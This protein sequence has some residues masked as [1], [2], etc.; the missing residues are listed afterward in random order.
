MKKKII[1][2]ITTL[3][4]CCALVL[5]INKVKADSGWDSDY[6]S[7]WDSSS[8]WDS[9]SSSSWDS[10]SRSSW[11]PNSGSGVTTYSDG[12]GS[13][14]ILVVFLIIIIA[15]L[16]M[17]KYNLNENITKRD[18]MK[19]VD[20]ELL[21]KYN[22][23][24]DSFKEEIFKK[25]VDIQNA[26]TNFDYDKLKNNLTDELYNSYVMQ[27]DTLKLKNQKNIMK[28]IKCVD[29]KIIDIKEEND[30]L[31][32][33]VYLRIRMYDYVINKE[34]S[35]VRGTDKQRLDIE[36]EITFVKTSKDNT[37]ETKCPNC[38]AKIEATA[39]GK[40]EYCGTVITINATDYVM[41]KK[42]NIGQRRL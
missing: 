25:Y 22:I 29:N 27:L 12:D 11:N 33:K 32:V 21:R 2:F 9:D 15:F 34:G 13:S 35:V 23:N 7:G 28:D 42:T 39:R 31:N 14:F 19:V 5:G 17:R 3:L 1:I 36:Y 30:L 16:I 37:K 8:D 10:D 4:C 26:W 20:D 38:G 18:D 6:D 40:C 41:S 24:K